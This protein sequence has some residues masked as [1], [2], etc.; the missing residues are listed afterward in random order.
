V[1]YG[2]WRFADQ[3]M[4]VAGLA[5][6][7]GIGLVRPP[8]LGW[9]PAGW[10]MV[11]CDVGQ[12]DATVVR[13]GPHSAV[14]ID[15]GPEPL[16]VDG[17]LRRLGVDHLPLAVITH[18]HADHLAGWPGAVRGRTVGRVLHGPSGGPGTLVATGDRFRV[19]QLTIEVVGPALDH[20]RVDAAD[21]TSM[22]DASVVLR[23]TTPS[24]AL[25]LAGD[26]E[27][28]AQ[29]KLLASGMPI[30]ADVLKFPHHGS[31]RQSP[32]FLRAVGA[33]VA[34]ISVGEGN[35]YGHP[36]REALE[37]LKQGGTSWHRTDLEG[38]IAIAARGGSIRVVARR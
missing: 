18:A 8:Q 7:L 37:M 31:G 11:T 13:A 6:G 21:G 27:T 33:R 38:D 4:V 20:P 25:L 15:A 23:V 9:P 1:G 29:E 36:D 19:G 24:A 10:I 28:E 26:V 17:C 30:D 14:L 12:G 5:I 22:N 2:L 3:P 16:T 34:T 32:D 35:D